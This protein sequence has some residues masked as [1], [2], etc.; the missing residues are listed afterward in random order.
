MV[1]NLVMWFFGYNLRRIYRDYH[2]LLNILTIYGDISLTCDDIVIRDLSLALR[3]HGILPRD[4]V[5]RAVGRGY[6]H[7][8]A[9]TSCF[10]VCYMYNFCFS[11]ID[12]NFWS[13]ST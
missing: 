7:F 8:R 6:S 5:H 10:I 2:F 3:D 1:V 11:I 12:Y 4:R 13:V 9:G